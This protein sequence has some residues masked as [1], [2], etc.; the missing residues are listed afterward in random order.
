[1]KNVTTIRMSRVDD[2]H[3]TTTFETSTCSDTPWPELVENVIM[4]GLRA[5]GFTLPSDTRVLDEIEKER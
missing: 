1:M 5:M 3:H 4:P 2:D